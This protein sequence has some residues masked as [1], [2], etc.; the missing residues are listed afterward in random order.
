M[1][2]PRQSGI[3]VPRKFRE[4]R[5]REMGVTV[6]GLSLETFAKL[7]RFMERKL[8]SSA[9]TTETRSKCLVVLW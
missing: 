9:K 1:E 8:R 3:D 2:L 7:L 4:K 5:W 6:G